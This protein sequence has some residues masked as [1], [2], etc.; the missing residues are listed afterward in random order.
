MPSTFEDGTPGV[1][2]IIEDVT[3][4]KLME[5][6]LRSNEES[7]NNFL[8]SIDD[9]LFVTDLDGKILHVNDT[10]IK[11]LGYWR[12]E[13]VGQPI[14]MVH[15]PGLQEQ[16]MKEMQAIMEGNASI[17]TVPLMAHDGGMIP[18]ETKVVRGTWDERSVNFGIA[19]DV[20]QLR[21]VEEMFSR[22]FELCPQAMIIST[23][24]GGRIIRVNGAFEQMSGYSRDEAIG[25][26]ISD[27][28]LYAD[29]N[30]SATM[31]MELRGSGR[32]AD[33]AITLQRK[34]GGRREGLLSAVSIGY[35]QASC[36]LSVIVET[37]D[38][39]RL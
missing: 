30:Q 6:S 32:I 16:A 29:P 26:T 36:A 4:T 11:R 28:D 20:S 37:A 35:S 19:K 3:E 25:S 34:D 18:V 31:I 2:M 10:V 38:R 14:Y 27:L 7:L 21:L 23:L 39:K 22:A 1:T 24:E 9:F 17:S 5:R 12:S 8:N 13:L 33:M 15:P